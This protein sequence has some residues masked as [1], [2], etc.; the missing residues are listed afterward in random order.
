MEK[1]GHS[2][3]QYTPFATV[4]PHIIIHFGCGINLFRSASGCCATVRVRVMLRMFCVPMYD[5]R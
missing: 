3:L 5:V 2:N 1:L 4:A